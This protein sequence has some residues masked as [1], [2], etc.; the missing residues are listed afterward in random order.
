MS[1]GYLE[2]ICFYLFALLNPF[3][4]ISCCSLLRKTHW[5]CVALLVALPQLLVYFVVTPKH[6]MCFLWAGPPCPACVCTAEVLDLEKPRRLWVLLWCAQQGTGPAAALPGQAQTQPGSAHHVPARGC[7]W[8]LVEPRP[9]G[10]G[11]HRWGTGREFHPKPV[12]F[13]KMLYY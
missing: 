13:Y 3:L 7:V 2:G 1:P 8:L 6:W 12:W 9:E 11:A 10:K 4:R 5:C